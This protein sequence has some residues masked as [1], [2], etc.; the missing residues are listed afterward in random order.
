MSL[1]EILKQPWSKIIWERLGLK[2]E[3]VPQNILNDPQDSIESFLNENGVKKEDFSYVL[4]WQIYEKSH[5]LKKNK[6]WEKENLFIEAGLG[7]GWI[8]G[9]TNNLDKYSK[10]LGNATNSSHLIGRRAEVEIISR[11]LCKSGQSNVLLVGEPGVGKGTLV[12]EF[13][14]L[15]RQGRT[16]SPLVYRRVISLDLNLALS[17][18]TNEGQIKDRLNRVFNEAASAGNII[19]VINDFHNYV[20]GAQDITQILAPYLEGAYFQLMALTTYENLHEQIEKNPGLLKFFEKVEIKE[21]DSEHA[22]LILQDSLEAIEIRTG[23]KITY[24][25][26]KEIIK[27]SDR[28]IADVPMPEK[29][30]D[31]L[32]ETA[33]FVASNTPD[34]FVLPHHVDS[35]ISQKTEIPIGELQSTEKEK[36]INLEGFLHQRIIGQDMAVKEIASAMRRARLNVSSQNRPFGSFLFL[37][38]TGVGKTETAKALAQSYFGNEE[39]I[40][41]FDMSE[42]QGAT[43]LE[44]LIGSSLS[45]KPGVFS[46]AAKENQFSL[47]LL[48]E[49]E[50]ADKN[51]LDL[52]LQVIDEGFLTDAFGHK[53]NFRNMI[54]IATS[55]AAATVIRETVQQGIEPETLKQ[56]ITDYILQN[57][58]FRPEFLN[59]FDGVIFFKPL[60]QTEIFEIAKLQ[61]SAL[62][63]RLAA[64]ELIFTPTES[65]ATKIAQMGYE[66]TSGARAMKRVIQNKV[67]DLIAKKMLSGEIQKNAAFEIKEEEIQ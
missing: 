8:Y 6:F 21:P 62:A 10:E 31:L 22:L 50:K 9:W 37:G 5:Q 33:I 42:Y 44:R 18:L 27:T 34:Y 64:Q 53:I 23:K 1:K 35:V 59:R 12:R 4:E 43:A 63:K 2:K 25:A 38:P 45:Q 29:A 51:V 15:V 40:L 7:Q 19:L 16:A 67:E 48:D 39:K 52:F 36:L 54:I 3:A 13:S 65:L 46:A 61:L 20:S 47:L 28:Y 56:K 32:E 11:I 41:R 24:Q 60:T 26:L 30:I 14:R 55:N 57:N 17:G 49:I 66:P 58:I